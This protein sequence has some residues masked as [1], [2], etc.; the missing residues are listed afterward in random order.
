MKKLLALLLTAV[1]LL[2]V[3]PAHAEESGQYD[4]LTVG[5]GTLF[6]GNFL[7]DAL[8]SNIIDQDIRKL[9]HG[10][11]L[12]YWDSAL[13][14]YEFNNP[15]VVTGQTISQNG[16]TF[17][18]SLSHALTYN[19][20]TPITARD[21]AF[22]LL[23]L[24]S[25]E[26]LE[27]AGG[28]EDISRIQGGAEYQAGTTNKLAG[29]R[30]LGDY[31]LVITI[32]PEY[33][34][35][36]YERKV[37]D[38]IP[39]PIDEIA[40]D[41]QVVDSQEGVYIEGVFFADLLKS[42][43]LDPEKGYVSHPKVTSG[44]YKLADY[45]GTTVTLELNT[46]YQPDADG[47]TPEIPRI[48]VRGEDP[49]SLVQD[50]EGGDLDL[51]V[52]VVRS[53]QITDGM[54]LA[55]EDGYAMKSYS[56]TGLS[57]ISFCGEKGPTADVRVREAIA[58]CLDKQALT[59]Q[60]LG[61]FGLT[62]KGYYGIG[63]W[64]F[65]MLN[66]SLH[67]EEGTEDQWEDLSLDQIPEYEMDT[68]TAAKLLT[69]AG[70]N[71]NENGDPYAPGTDGIRYCAED[72]KLKSLKLKLIY[73]EGNGAG[74]L[75]DETFIPY[76]E[77]AGIGLETE[78]LPMP[79]LLEYYYGRKARDCDMILLGTNFADV[80][81]P[82]GEYDEEGKSS[83]NGVT[84]PRLRELAIR[85]RSTEPGNISEYCR[86]WLTYQVCRSTVIPEIPLYSDAYFDFH[87]AELQNY[88]PA[89]T[90]NWA[91]AL[92]RAH[93]GDVAEEEETGEEELGEGEMEFDD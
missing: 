91:I 12:V 5:T 57:Y 68:E 22:S 71:L 86:R 62:V 50:L 14:A 17:T 85:M 19:N 49:E 69:V 73:P 37:L 84:E 83:T 1:L 41:C 42:T 76:L 55:R 72:G 10:Y 90:G 89:Q 70:W 38:I 48:V 35:Y 9:I 24:G 18:I 88:D 74:P 43:L 67:P 21:Y 59:E 63:Q 6:S 36:F 32:A 29:V 46:R 28:R 30:V 53:E 52:R 47:N 44:P 33:E 65:L 54:M 20:G 93:L 45:D 80:F 77:E 75:L 82:C 61:N 7:S 51:A 25:R 87:I 78:A 15:Q 23:L 3:F 11:S 26:L 4:Q 79:E 31:Q 8:G 92:T 39:L 34:T 56:R 16:R 27:A 40:P 66:G 13:G 60:Y 64:M 81:D 2:G 58:R